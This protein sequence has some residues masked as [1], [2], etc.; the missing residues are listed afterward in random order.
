ML[1]SVASEWWHR[2]RF[3]LSR[4]T[5]KPADVVDAETRPSES[6]PSQHDD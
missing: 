1:K 6:L 5:S 3:L 2:A 4:M